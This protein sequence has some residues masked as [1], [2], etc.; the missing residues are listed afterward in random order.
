[1]NYYD[2]VAAVIVYTYKVSKTAFYASFF[3]MI[4]WRLKQDKGALWP[5]VAILDQIKSRDLSLDFS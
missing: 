3:K 1:M 5:I 2:I 4:F